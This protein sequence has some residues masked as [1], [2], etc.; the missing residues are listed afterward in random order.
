METKK[1][2][3]EKYNRELEE[4]EEQLK[5]VKAGESSGIGLINQIKSL[6]ICAYYDGKCEGVQQMH[7]ILKN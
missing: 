7:E 5:L 2:V 4:I 6:T 1:T 3:V